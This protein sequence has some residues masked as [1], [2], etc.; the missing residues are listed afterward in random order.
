MDSKNCGKLSKLQRDKKFKLF[1]AQTVN[2]KTLL[3]SFLV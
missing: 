1:I 2:S 3:V